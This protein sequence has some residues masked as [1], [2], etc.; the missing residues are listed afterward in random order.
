[1]KGPAK[2]PV[3]TVAVLAAVA[4]LV[5]SACGDDSTSVRTQSSSTTSSPTTS[6][7]P[8]S[9]AAPN[10][11]APITISVPPAPPPPESPATTAP[12]P[13]TIPV[14]VAPATADTKAPST[15]ASPPSPSTVP[16][17]STEPPSSTT[18]PLKPVRRA[19]VYTPDGAPARKATLVVPRPDH[20]DTVV[21]L[22]H[23]GNGTNGNRRQVRGW[24][25]FYADNGITSLAI[26]YFL[27]KG[28]TPP[29]V[30]PQPERDVKAAVQWVREH[31]AD[32]AIDPDR[33]VVQGFGAGAALGA[34]AYVTPGDPFFAGPGLEPGVSDA[35]G[36]FVGFA[37]RYDG[38]QRNPAQYYGGPPDSE[39]PV[40]QARYEQANSVAHAAD[41]SGPALLFQA[42]NGTPALVD[43]ARAFDEALVAAGVDS[44]LV[45]PPSADDDFDTAGK[46][47]TPAG[48]AAAQ[49][50]LAWLAARFPPS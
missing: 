28:S 36:A 10:T 38:E 37:G 13:N 22:V 4:A 16:P 5:L 41:A 48:E 9:T 23:G 32:L 1:M 26:D 40:V 30:Y 2:L 29:P 24:Q 33:I 12:P 27:Y 20:L 49:Q 31:A 39:D 3:A 34:Q 45:L 46:E 8:A 14:S 15:S 35:S 42:A 47:L 18:V 11:A 17:P 6:T 44:E 43:Q 50:V 21:V 19:V 7:A 25:D